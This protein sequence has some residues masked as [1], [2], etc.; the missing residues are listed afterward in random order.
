VGF[1]ALL[2]LSSPLCD[3]T[4]GLSRFVSMS[5]L[6]SSFASYCC[7]SGQV[8]SWPQMLLHQDWLGN[9]WYCMLC[10]M[11]GWLMSVASRVGAAGMSVAQG[12]QAG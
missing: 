12:Q 2:S 3:A 1:L 8:H 7:C 5:F 10:S 11:W 9:D 6:A 4:I